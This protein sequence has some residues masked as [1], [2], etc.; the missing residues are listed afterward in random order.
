MVNLMLRTTQWLVLSLLFLLFPAA[1]SSGRTTGRDFE[2]LMATLAGAWSQQDTELAL[3]CFTEDAIYMQPPDQQLYRGRGELETLFRLLRP[4]T[5]MAFHNL[6][7]NVAAQVGF[8]EFS[9]GR[10]GAAK[11]DHGV[12]VV[13]LRG[14]RIASWR[15]Y[16]EEGPPVFFRVRGGRGQAMEGDGEGASVSDINRER[17]RP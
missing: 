9:F 7:F 8:G 11:A 5:F 6:A 3:G 4:G 17:L 2:R 12:V 15:E 13:T 16:F 10:A 14:G 1:G